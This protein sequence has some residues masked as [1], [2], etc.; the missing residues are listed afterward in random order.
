M[1]I[2]YYSMTNL[3]P[4]NKEWC[5]LDNSFS[6]LLQNYMGKG[7]L[8]KYIRVKGSTCNISCLS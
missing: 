5:N 8:C 4:P 3:A 7:P 6:G 2:F 1:R